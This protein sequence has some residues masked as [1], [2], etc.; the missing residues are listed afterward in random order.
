MVPRSTADGKQQQQQQKQRQKKRQRTTMPTTT[1]K[2]IETLRVWIEGELGIIEQK[3]SAIKEADNLLR[4]QNKVHFENLNNEG[5]RITAMTEKTV[6]QDTWNGFIKQNDDRD[7]AVQHL[8]STAM[9]KE[10]F[11]MFKATTERA[12]TLSSGEL[13]G[14]GD[15]WGMLVAVISVVIS[16]GT[17]LT[18]ILHQ[19]R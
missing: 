2:S 8:T 12:L 4:E 3:F 11:Q 7:K 18:L 14:R 10:E 15:V 17:L 19:L 16:I 13:K 6:S 5:K 9:T 1:T